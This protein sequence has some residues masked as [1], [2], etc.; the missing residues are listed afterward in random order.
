[1]IEQNKSQYQAYITQGTYKQ[2]QQFQT[3][4]A[5]M[6]K[7][8][9]WGDE[10]ILRAVADLLRVSI[11]VLHSAGNTHEYDGGSTAELHIAF[12]KKREHYLGTALLPMSTPIYRPHEMRG[13]HFKNS[14][15]KPMFP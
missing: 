11:T 1:M 5:K 12:N 13:L 3:Y 9:E 10:V 14:C 7:T 4:L 2:E 6:K 15:S 8:G